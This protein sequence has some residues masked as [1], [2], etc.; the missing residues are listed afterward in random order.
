M[1]PSSFVNG[2]MP[3]SYMHVAMSSAIRIKP[4]LRD[5]VTASTPPPIAP[6]LSSPLSITE[7]EFPTLPSREYVGV[8][9]RS[10]SDCGSFQPGVQV[11]RY[12]N[13]GFP[14]GHGRPPRR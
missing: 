11:A 14:L 8:S 12:N 6:D 13:R 9:D 10:T 5:Q 3:V 4:S 2:S 1:Y 7:P